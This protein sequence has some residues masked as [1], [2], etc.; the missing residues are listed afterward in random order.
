MNPSCV[1]E[2]DH[3]AHERANLRRAVFAGMLGGIAGAFAMSQFS[4]LWASAYPASVGSPEKHKVLNFAAA[5]GRLGRPLMYASQQ[6]WDSTLNAATAVL[7][8]LLHR[9]LSEPQRERGAVAV[10]Y[11]VGATVGAAYAAVREYMPEAGAASGAAFGAAVWLVFEET[12]MP[13][14]GWTR[15]PRQYS[16]AEHANAFGEHIAFG[17]TTETVRRLLRGK[18]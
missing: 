8:R 9:P 2:H 17:V 1:R 16:L 12:G 6:E 13:L 14:L 10:H 4:R 18:P 7:L 3:A 15:P 11:A 5:R